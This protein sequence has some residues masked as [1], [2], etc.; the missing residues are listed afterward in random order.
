MHQG[1]WGQR[2]ERLQNLSKQES[3]HTVDSFNGNITSS[4]SQSCSKSSLSIPNGCM[5]PDCLHLRVLVTEARGS[6]RDL[7]D[8][9][10][11]GS[12]GSGWPSFLPSRISSLI[13]LASDRASWLTSSNGSSSLPDTLSLG[14]LLAPCSAHLKLSRGSSS[15]SSSNQDGSSLTRLLPRSNRQDLRRGFITSL[16]DIFMEGF[17]ESKS[18]LLHWNSS[19]SRRGCMPAL[20]L[21]FSLRCFRLR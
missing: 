15:D 13:W 6:A 17:A 8:L 4:S 16:A 12:S 11:V 1:C 9:E 18:L 5:S 2:G 10:S 21:F 14:C 3:I 7:S 20:C 19:S